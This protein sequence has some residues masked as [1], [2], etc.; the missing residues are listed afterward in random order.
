[1]KKRLSNSDIE[2]LMIPLLITSKEIKECFP[3]IWRDMRKRAC[4]RF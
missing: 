4:P 3:D 1:L 2:E